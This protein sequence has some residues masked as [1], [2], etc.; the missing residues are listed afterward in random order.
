MTDSG[1]K[2]SFVG[3]VPY[4][5]PTGATRNKIYIRITGSITTELMISLVH[6]L[7]QMLYKLCTHMDDNNVTTINMVSTTPGMVLGHEFMTVNKSI[8]SIVMQ[9]SNAN[10]AKKEET[11]Q[12]AAADGKDQARADPLPISVNENVRNALVDIEVRILSSG[13]DPDVV[14][15]IIDQF[16][17]WRH[18]KLISTVQT[19][20]MGLVASCALHLLTIAD[21]GRRHIT[22]L[23]C[24]LCHSASMSSSRLFLTRH[25]VGNMQA[26]AVT[27]YNFNRVLPDK[28]VDKIEASAG[29]D[30]YLTAD[31][32]LQFGFADIIVG[33]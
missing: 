32:M 5:S 15:Y 4:T 19:Y 1:A 11:K 21:P 33:A 14:A 3:P 8:S 22:S 6:P 30:T 9:S 27:H 24:G 23:T 26:L 18:K 29:Y 2:V 12:A 28:A 17:L 7:E 20:G 25:T 31:D 10:E 16:R 13:G